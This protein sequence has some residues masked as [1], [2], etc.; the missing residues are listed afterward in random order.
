MPK[1]TF[2]F[3]RSTVD[4]H[5][6]G[7]FSALPT[8][9]NGANTVL[10]TDENVMEAHKNKLK[11][12]K[13]IVI[14]PGESEKNAATVNDVIA[15]LIAGGADRSTVL[16]GVGGGVVT[17]LAGYVASIYMRGIQFGFIPTTLLAMVDAS[18]G[19]KNGI[20]VGAYKNMV[21]T[22]NQ[23]QFILQDASLLRSLPQ[24]EWNNGFAEVIKHAAIRDSALFKTLESY[25]PRHFRRD[26][27]LTATLVRRN[28][29]LKTKI[30]LEDEFEKG[31][32]KL[33]NF[34]HT[35]GHAIENEYRLQHGEAVA[36]G[37]VFAA[38]L[39]EQLLKFRGR[40]RLRAL[41][42]RYGLPTECVY[43]SETVFGNMQ[44][45][46]KN[47]AGLLSY[48]LLQKIGKGIIYKIP[49]EQV[50]QFLQ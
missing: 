7:S 26:T 20:D 16:V 11:R 43:D 49:F 14:K 17:D 23:P 24:R 35:L 32:R 8:I 19:G 38:K 18:I 44:K 40:E 25:K 39:S 31:D 27:Q 9:L 10:L 50:H 42:E 28:S 30:V 15:Q 2:H 47:E 4:Y 41:I 1:K 45:D 3:S 33:L 48:V 13:T 21:G 5:F 34:G 37:M 22:I 29:L 46:K 36:I 6:E 12:W